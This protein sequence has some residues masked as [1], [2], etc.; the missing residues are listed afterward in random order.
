[1][2]HVLE[3]CFHAQ[4]QCTNRGIYDKNDPVSIAS[5]L[6]NLSLKNIS[7]PE[8][9]LL[10]LYPEKT[11]IEKDTGT[12]IFIAALFTIARTWKQRRC[13]SADESIKKL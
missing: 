12:P 9:P 10:G 7:D 3:S 1:M 4:A 6:I 5:L 2:Y 13:P 11:I 8:S